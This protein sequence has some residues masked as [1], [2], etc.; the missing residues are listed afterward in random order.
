M[1]LST[2]A[3]RGLDRLTRLDPGR[4]AWR[5]AVA[6]TTSLGAALVTGYGYAALVAPSHGAALPMIT[7]GVM[8]MQTSTAMT[9]PRWAGRLHVALWAPLFFGSGLLI[10]I[11]VTT[12]GGV[13]AEM[14][15]F[16][17]V[18]FVAVG[19]RRFGPDF[20]V[21]GL[22]GWTGFYIGAFA[23]PSFFEVVRLLGGLAIA[24]P[25]TFAVSLLFWPH[26]PQN[27][28]AHVL[29]AGRAQTDA[30]LAD[31]AA[32]LRPSTA[33]RRQRLTRRM[34]NRSRRLTEISLLADGWLAHG[35]APLPATTPHSIRRHLLRMHASIDTVV[36]TV[37]G[38]ADRPEDPHTHTVR[39]IV[40]ALAGNDADLAITRSA[41]LLDDRESTELAAFAADA[42]ELATLRA[43]VPA[44]DE[45][46]PAEFVPAVSMAPA[47][48]L[49][50]SASIAPLV[51]PGGGP[52]T[53]RWH[54]ATRQAI[55]ATLAVAI[56]TVAGYLL[57]AEHY[58]WAALTAFIIYLGTSTR[59][60][61]AVKALYRAIGTLA[62]MVIAVP[63]VLASGTNPAMIIGVTLLCCAVG[64]YL[65]SVSYV[66]TMLC[67]TVAVSE[68]YNS[69]GQFDSALTETRIAEIVIGAII[70]VLVAALVAPIST[71][72]AV[73]HARRQLFR[74]IHDLLNT[75]ADHLHDQRPVDH[76]ELSRKGRVVD[77]LAR[78]LT[79]V[80]APLRVLRIGR[81]ASDLR[82]T[83][84]RYEE[85]GLHTRR[86]VTSLPELPAA[87]A[88]RAHQHCRDVARLAQAVAEHTE[89]TPEPTRPR[90]R[91]Q[92]PHTHYT[93]RCE[94]SPKN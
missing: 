69:M 41:H 75:T 71:T 73:T 28:L 50:G 54:L 39:V 40:T 90:P 29:R 51:R 68:M 11:L 89:N 86:I 6:A 4:V 64:H 12:L 76:H 72:D 18:T 55:Q 27:A 84:R 88:E 56:A 20:G 43:E 62:G 8:A 33:T 67:I 2:R 53:A 60:D 61:V 5:R 9:H 26:R 59:G 48:I 17:A 37:S 81:A 49:A 93:T 91:P 87:H 46:L 74:S 82:A 45:R 65:M 52:R 63:I 36:H 23:D 1:F 14:V 21:L 83:L 77:E 15:A 16:T 24:A 25:L 10:H 58:T 78:Q 32:V 3:P 66:Y 57:S 47:G 92:P 42:I 22:T 35:A 13:P 30:V 19:V 94:P 70:A 79:A 38:A 31:A 85:Y 34:I 7:S 44:S 80:A